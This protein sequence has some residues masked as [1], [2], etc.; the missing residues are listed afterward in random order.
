MKLFDI[1]HAHHAFIAANKVSN[2]LIY[3]KNF[4]LSVFDKQPAE[5]KL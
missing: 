1:L 3:P 4:N 2:S 5:Y